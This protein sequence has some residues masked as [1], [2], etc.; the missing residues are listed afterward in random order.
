[1]KMLDEKHEN[2]FGPFGEITETDRKAALDLF[3]KML[4]GARDRAILQWDQILE[5]KHRYPVW[6]RLVAANPDMDD[7]SR[8]AIKN[9]LPHIVDTFMYCLLDALE[10]NRSVRVNVVVNERIV[11]DIA[12]V[13]WGL[14][15][16][17]TTDSGWLAKFSTQRF[18]Q[19]S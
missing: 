2:P 5:G 3:G 12:R 8:F 17:P 16:E 19:P 13:S 11:N 4:I 14:V 15:A 10:S 1:M 9:S 18:E 7:R 6:D